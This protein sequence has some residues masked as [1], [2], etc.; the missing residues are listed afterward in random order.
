MAMKALVLAGGRGN[1]INE[2]S[3]RQNKCMVEVRG[4]HLIEYNMDC[5]I[6]VGVDEI[7][8]VVGYKAETI[9]NFLGNTYKGTRIRYVIQTEQKGL[10]HAIECAQETVD[11]A[12]FF[13]MLGDEI[14]FNPKH[15]AMIAEFESNSD[16]FG[17]CGIVR[18]ADR[19][20]IR[21]TYTMIKGASNDIYRLIEKPR[22][23]L[24]EF[25][26]TGH[27]VFRNQIYDYIKYTPIHHE[28]NEKELPDLIQCA[29]D[30]AMT[31]KAFM[32]CE[33]YTNVNTHED[34][35][36]AEGFFV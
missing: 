26:G 24:N 20:Q 15:Q 21:K 34:I 6:D 23:P 18:V 31:I 14:L 36:L 22:H 29:I 30:D 17:I 9:I 12:D 13:L 16:I 3:A 10:V 19:N 27:C 25:Q 4:K 33:K 32:I 35:R 7:V 5:A 11:G 28:R 2:L 1:R 8:L